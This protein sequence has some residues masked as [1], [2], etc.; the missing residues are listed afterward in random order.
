[1]NVRISRFQNLLWFL[2]GQRG[3]S[4]SV[5]TVDV[6]PALVGR[7]MLE[8]RQ[9]WPL[10]TLL[11]AWWKEGHHLPEGAL[12]VLLQR[13]AALQV[14]VRVGRERRTGGF[15]PAQCSE[16]LGQVGATPSHFSSAFFKASF[17]TLSQSP[18]A[19]VPRGV[20]LLHTTSFSVPY[21][22]TLWDLVHP[23]F[24]LPLAW[25]RYHLSLVS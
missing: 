25:V 18:D 3:A 2:L 6:G 10:G 24:S 13:G 4:P 14:E 20:S 5:S 23:Y 9:H 16:P 22:I 21:L 11:T 17:H 8:P 12:G 1:M 19:L 7:W 15:Q